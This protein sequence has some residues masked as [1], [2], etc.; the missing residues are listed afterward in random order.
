MAR[1][2]MTNTTIAIIPMLISICT[3]SLFAFVMY[4]LV[5]YCMYHSI[6]SL[7]ITELFSHFSVLNIAI[8]AR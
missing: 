1:M 8:Y 2:A 3:P 4:E 5:S 6:E 7:N